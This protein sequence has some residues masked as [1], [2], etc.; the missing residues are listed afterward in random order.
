MARY[1][2][3]GRRARW[4]FAAA[5]YV[6][7]SALLVFFLFPLLWIV[8]LSFKTRVQTFADPPLF[9]WKPTLENYVAVLVPAT[10]RRLS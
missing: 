4:R 6:A 2:S 8:G 5:V 10:S 7:L 9:F 3:A 1:R